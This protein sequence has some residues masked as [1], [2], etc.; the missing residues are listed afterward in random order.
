MTTFTVWKFDSPDGAGQAA[1]ALRYAENDGLVEVYDHA[2]VSWPVGAGIGVL[3]GTT[4]FAVTE[5]GEL[6]R[7]GERFHGMNSTLVATNLTDGEREILL[8]TFGR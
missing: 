2:V 3:S 5:R 4:L 7:L 8:E 6:D 1:R